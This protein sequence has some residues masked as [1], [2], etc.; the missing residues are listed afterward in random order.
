MFSPFFKVIIVIR[1]SFFFVAIFLFSC[2]QE[3]SDK[4]SSF[5]DRKPGK[6]ILRWNSPTSNLDG[7][8]LT[9]LSGYKLYWGIAPLR[10]EDS[11]IIG[12]VNEH[13]LTGLRIGIR[14]YFSIKAYDTSGNESGFSSEVYKDIP[15][16]LKLNFVY[17]T[18][19]S[20]R[21]SDIDGWHPYYGEIYD[22]ERGYGWLT[23]ALSNSGRDRG[24]KS[25]IIFPDAT[26]GNPQS[27]VRLELASW[28]G[29]HKENE[30]IVFRIDLP[31]GWYRITCTSVDAGIILPVVDQRSFKCRSHDVVFSGASYGKPIVVRGQQLVE[32]TGL[33]EVTEGHLRIVIGDP[34]YG[35]WA[36]QH[37]GPWYRG[38][39]RWLGNDHGYANGWDQKL[40]RIVDPGF[41]MLRLN[42]LEV[43]PVKQPAQ[44]PSLVFRDYFNR[45]NALNINEGVAKGSQWDKL[46]LHPEISGAI[47]SELY[48]TS[49]KVSGATERPGVVGFLQEQVSPENGIIRYSSRVSLFTGEGSKIHSGSQEAGLFFLADPAEPNEFNGTFLGIGFDENRSKS[50]GYLIYRV[51]DGGNG[52]RTN[53]EFPDSSLP[54]NIA[55]GEYEII[56]EHDIKSNVLR[57][58]RVNGVD[59]TQKWSL[60][61]RTQRIHNG[62]FGLRSAIQNT[63]EVILKQFYWYFRVERI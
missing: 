14:Y 12:K 2:V 46:K 40:A 21:F 47:K 38:W 42:S 44:L 32:G 55:E 33:V 63:S 41:H 28:Q 52:Y 62:R 24:F 59:V 54:M 9:D 31:N 10:Y 25:T 30:P 36:W 23:R 15:A 27:R 11:I 37:E 57:T 18:Q 60:K 13:T 35:G 17:K 61:D 39:I 50:R 45:D 6:A 22:S 26:E 53:V 29:T 8:A 19:K 16:R 43:E 3:K 58:I 51:G 4:Q 49:I 1:F 56:V 7:T 48:Q 5:L 20:H 34:A